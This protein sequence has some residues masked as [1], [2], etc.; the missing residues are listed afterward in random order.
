MSSERHI[1]AAYTDHTITVYQAYSAQIANAAVAASTF[2]P[3][4]K[5]D[6]MTW[7]KPSFLWMMYR[8]GWARKPGQEHIL[9]VEIS[10]EGFEWALYNSCLSHFDRDLYKRFEDWQIQKRAMPVRIQWD[11]DRSITLDPLHRRAIQIGL[12]GEAVNRYLDQWIISIRDITTLAKHISEKVS[13][14]DLAAA[15]AAL[16]V[17]QIYPLPEA[18]CKQVSADPHP[19]P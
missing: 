6:R 16:P 8:S 7:I 15:D 19:H 2:V 10:R 11:P 1:R 13:T 5:R 18:I 4:F 14:G 3:P 17:E 9:A 12:S